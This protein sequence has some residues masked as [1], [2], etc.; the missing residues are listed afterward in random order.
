MEKNGAQIIS[1]PISSEQQEEIVKHYKLIA[2]ECLLFA[3][4]IFLTSDDSQFMINAGTMNL[5]G[6]VDAITSLNDSNKKL[7][8]DFAEKHGDA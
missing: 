5:N 3:S 4:T 6:L 2:K 7:V 8:K 1:M